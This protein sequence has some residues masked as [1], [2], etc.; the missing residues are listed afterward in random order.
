MTEL[1]SR[2]N[3][4]VLLRD[5]TGYRAPQGR[6]SQDPKVEVRIPVYA[7]SLIDRF[8]EVHGISRS[9]V[10]REAI[11]LFLTGYPCVPP[12]LHAWL[13]HTAIASELDSPQAA[14][15]AIL[16]HL[17]RRFPTGW[18]VPTY[19]PSGAGTTAAR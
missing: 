15:E 16:N 12:E 18:Q 8:A 1:P 9:Q 13:H 5:P 17:A 19:D 2:P 3:R 4:P 10:H 11:N 14:I 6:V 7:R